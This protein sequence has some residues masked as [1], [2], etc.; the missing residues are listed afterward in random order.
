MLWEGSAQALWQH[1]TVSAAVLSVV[2]LHRAPRRVRAAS[3][4]ALCRLYLAT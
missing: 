2:R 4:Q 1:A 3:A